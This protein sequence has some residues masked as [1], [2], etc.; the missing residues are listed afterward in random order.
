MVFKTTLNKLQVLSVL[1]LLT[2]TVANAQTTCSSDP[3]TLP[4]NEDFESATNDYTSSTSTVSGLCKWEYTEDNRGRLRFSQVSNTGNKAALF[5]VNNNGSYTENNLIKTLNLS[6]YIGATDLELSFWFADFG[7][8]NHS[9]DGVWIRGND[10]ANWILVYRIYAQN[11]TDNRWNEIKNIDIDQLLNAAGQSVSSTFQIKLSQ[12]DNY[13][14]SND[15][16]AYDDIQITGTIGNVLDVSSLFSEDFEDETQGATNGTDL[17]G[18]DW[19]TTDDSTVNGRFE[20]RNGNHFEAD[21][22]DGPAKWVTNPITISGFTNLSLSAYISFG[23]GLDDGTGRGNLD[24]IKFMYKLDG[25]NAVEIASYI[26]INSNGDYTWDLSN[27]TGSTLELIIEF[28]SDN[29]NNEIH[30]IDNINLTGQKEKPALWKNDI[31][32]N[33]SHN[34]NPYTANDVFNSDITVSGISRGNGIAGKGRNNRYNADGWGSASFD[35]NDY[36]EFTLTPTV[37]HEMNF[38]SFVFNSVISSGDNIT[39]IEVRTSLDNFATSIGSVS[40]SGAI[41][42][43]TTQEFQAV[44][45]PITFRIYAWG[46]NSS[47]TELGI[48]NFA[49]YGSIAHYAYWNGTSWENNYLPS[50]SYKTVIADDYDTETQGS[51]SCIQLIINEGKKL[52]VK[53]N[54]YVEVENNVTVN[55]ELVVETKG[56]FVQRDNNAVFINN[57]SSKVNKSTPNKAQWYYYTYWSSPVKDFN[58]ES[59]FWS[60]GGKFYFDGSAWQYATGRTMKA[61]E[62]FITRADDAGVQTATFTG[63]FNT[64]TITTPI[65]YDATNNVKFNLIGN[66]YPSSI[67]LNQFLDTNKDVIEGVAYFWS[68]ETPPV[69]GQFDASDYIPYNLTG[70]VSTSTD[71]TRT[72]NGFVPSAQ[73]FFAISKAAGNATFTNNMRM[74]D[75][76]SNS[77]FF[78]SSNAAPPKGLEGKAEKLWVNLSSSN[79]VFSQILVGYI[80]GATNEDDGLTYDATKF[81]ESAGAFLYSTILNSDKKFVIQGKD[82]NSINIDEVIALGFKTTVATSYTISIAK[83][84][85]DFINGNTIYLKDNMLNIIHDL[86]SND[87]TFNSEVGEFNNRFEIVFNSQALSTNTFNAETNNLKIVELNDNFIQFSVPNST[88][89]K[90]VDIFDLLGKHIVDLKGN[91][92]IEKHQFNNLTA[93]I[94][95]AEVTLNDGVVITKKFIKK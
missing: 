51:F 91:S 40:A 77:Q 67:D 48:D 38:D 62:G 49:F 10:T 31:T 4:W 26:G 89:I 42:D 80:D 41:I 57:G 74:A 68:Q 92:S 39:N 81:S 11:F 29:S 83:L 84:E 86:S 50:D 16:I 19:N 64:G 87:Y 56:A 58:I 18:T 7:D 9:Q 23:S 20:V 95:I 13:S 35:A 88:S 93:S 37:S 65:F 66:P 15:G 3:V 47:A 21:E 27:V 85:G 34:F 12:Y 59:I 90:K 22:T 82:V 63:E 46:A 14:Y 32:T 71:L 52:S 76:T 17:Y 61:G 78:K 73:S 2:I 44:S 72:V 6:D 54:T 55:G 45:T 70:S 24:Y 60:I 36:F 94:Y 5:D 53:N 43:L 25:G 79:G 30:I 28:Q 8:E 33:D 69:G 1:F 75:A